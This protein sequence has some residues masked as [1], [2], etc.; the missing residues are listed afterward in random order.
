MSKQ[1]KRRRKLASDICGYIANGL[2]IGG[3][4]ATFAEMITAPGIS[5]GFLF[6]V[7]RSLC[8]SALFPWPACAGVAGDGMLQAESANQRRI[9]PDAL[10]REV[11]AQFAC[12]VARLRV[13]EQVEEDAELPPVGMAEHQ[14]AFVSGIA[15]VEKFNG[16]GQMLEQPFV[17]SADGVIKQ[18]GAG[19]SEMNGNLARLACFAPGAR[20]HE[21]A[22]V[23]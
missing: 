4:L 11:C 15:L 1:A 8:H 17:S 19:A 10:A 16:L 2:F 3:R 9:D 23:D 6:W 22:H 5:A 13:I 14:T 7:R 20:K 18:R 21:R 12:L